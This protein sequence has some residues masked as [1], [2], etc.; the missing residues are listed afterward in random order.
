MS[1]DSGDFD[2]PYLPERYRQKV[3]VKRRRRLVKRAVLGL[4]LVATLLAVIILS[5][6]FSSGGQ[7]LPALLPEQPAPVNNLATVPLPPPGA[8]SAPAPNA[9]ATR[10][11]DFVIGPGVPA[12]ASDGRISLAD[13]VVA[14]R[15]F[16]PAQKYAILSVN[17]S[18]VSGHALYGFI[19]RPSGSG[20][21]D[22]TRVSI[23]AAS[24]EPWVPGQDTAPVSA[25]QAAS[26]ARSI[27]P[28]LNPDRSDVR[29]RSDPVRGEVWDFTLS[30]GGMELLN[31]SIDAAAG[32]VETF[33]RT[34]SPADRPAAPPIGQEQ[35]REIASR[36]I[37]DHTIGAHPVNLTGSVY[38]PWTTPSGPV[39]GQYRFIYDRIFSGY[40]TDEDGFVVTV[41]SANGD[42]T[43]YDQLWTTQDYAFSEPVEPAVTRRDAGLAVIRAASDAL[44]VPSESIG[45]LSEGIVWQ[46]RHPPGTVQRPGSIPLRWKVVFDD[47]FIRSDPSL[48]PA[49]GWVDIRT[50]NVTELD[51]RH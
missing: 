25:G 46:N 24:G 19:V 42:V 49:T 4:I 6:L 41:D 44:S 15:R 22:G 17:F 1:G 38:E 43:G 51:Y 5:G 30:T 12:G 31:G 47:D 8:S 34:V 36:F 11:P 18:T 48:P 13:A 33:Y 39:A 32:V 27:V 2:E 10:S 37:T 14:L 29:F 28:S 3:L 45:I 20:S 50:G 21:G 16:Y 7:T 35:A 40:P 23:D 26:I 9:T